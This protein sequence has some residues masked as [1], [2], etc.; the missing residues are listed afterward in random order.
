VTFALAL[1]SFAAQKE[2][3]VETPREGLSLWLGATDDVWKLGKAVGVGGPWRDSLVTAG[4]PSDPYL[5]RLTGDCLLPC[6]L[7][8]RQTDYGPAT[9]LRE[10]WYNSDR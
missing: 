3:V 1:P 4:E 5:A 10:L 9:C 2:D 7:N 8:E 6:L